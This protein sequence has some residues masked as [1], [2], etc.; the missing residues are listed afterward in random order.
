MNEPKKKRGRKPKNKII[1]NENPV[2]D[3]NSLDDILISC[4]KKPQTNISVKEDEVEP[5]DDIKDTFENFDHKIINKCWNC[6]YDIKGE[7]Y[8]FPVSYFNGIFHING[9]FCSNECSARY[10]YDNY[11]HKE[12]W[13]KYYLLNFYVNLRCNTD[14]KVN[15]PLSKLRL[16]DYGGD[17]T[18]EEYLKS[19]NITYD[20]YIPPTL[21]VNNIYY[22]KDTINNGTEFK[23]FRKN[24]KKNNFLENLT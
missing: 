21:Y 5:H 18:I 16:I 3:S 4:I 14:T 9:N 15:I 7:V 2:F 23:L 17:L 10:L 13:D 8:S 20:Y 6:S 12:F 19:K 22:N 1:S 24:K 11:N